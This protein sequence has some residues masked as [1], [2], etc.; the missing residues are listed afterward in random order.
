MGR[1]R[2][3]A[4]GLSLATAAALTSAI[5]AHSGSGPPFPTDPVTCLNHGV[6]KIRSA[7]QYSHLVDRVEVGYRAADNTLRVHYGG[8]SKDEGPYETTEDCTLPGGTWRRIDASMDSGGDTVR[9]DAK[10]LPAEFESVPAPI[11]SRINGGGTRDVLLGHAG[12]DELRGG[13]SFD[14]LSG[15]QGD[16]L[17]V[18]GQRQD[19][20]L[21][22]KGDDV[23]RAVDG[24][25]RSDKIRCGDGTDVAFVDRAD[26][27][28]GCE[29]IKRR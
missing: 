19:T 26:N 11:A 25:K 12:V 13:A 16:D 21:A 2:K 1:G 29:R 10:G 22:G 15:F 5:P 20:L 28:A 23:V 24:G 8:A 18:G 14:E 3:A 4:V 6:V 17:L 7:G 27:Y 9:L